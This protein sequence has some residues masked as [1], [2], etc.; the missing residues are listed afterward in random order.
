MSTLKY[1][2]NMSVES[3]MKPPGNSQGRRCC[4]SRARRC[5]EPRWR[6]ST[7]YSTARSTPAGDTHVSKTGNTTGRS[8]F[9]PRVTYT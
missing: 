3:K 1:L 5:S 4:Y 6:A 7:S 8:T 2:A 9:T